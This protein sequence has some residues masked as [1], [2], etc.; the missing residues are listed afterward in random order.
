MLNTYRVI[1]GVAGVNSGCIFYVWLEEKQNLILQDCLWISS[2]APC[3]LGSVG[4]EAAQWKELCFS[5]WLFHWSLKRDIWLF[6]WSKIETKKK[7]RWAWKR[8]VSREIITPHD[9]IIISFQSLVVNNSFI[10]SRKVRQGL[11]KGIINYNYFQLFILGF[12]S[13]NKKYLGRFQITS[14]EKSALN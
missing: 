14:S 11:K 1:G 8:N 4:T 5:V 2:Q 9:N 13:S 12:N 6:H 3:M 7:K 10:L